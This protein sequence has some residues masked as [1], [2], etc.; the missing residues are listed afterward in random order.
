MKP[1]GSWWVGGRLSLYLF[2]FFL[3]FSPA[4]AV[5]GP[6]TLDLVLAQALAHSWDLHIARKGVDISRYALWEARSLYFPT[7]TARFDNQYVEDLTEDG[8][9]VVS[10]GDQ[11]VSIDGSTYQH[12]VGI[13]LSYLLFDFGAREL[14]VGNTQRDVRI[15]LLKTDQALVDTRLKVL[16]AFARCLELSRRWETGQ[17]ILGHRQELF[18]LTG[19]LRRSGGVG[20]VEVNDAALA[21]AEAVT[22]QEAL[23]RDLEEA[24]L[25]LSY[26]TGED[27]ATE[28]IDFAPLP[29]LAEPEGPPSPELLPEIRAL[30]EEIRKKQ[31]EK[32]ALECSMLPSISLAG[33]YRALGY[34]QDSFSTSLENLDSRDVSV[35][36]VVRWE[37]FSGFRDVSRTLRLS[38]EAEQLKLEKERRLSDLRREMQGAYQAYRLS[39]INTPHIRQRENILGQRAVTDQRLAARQI[40]DRMTWVK[41]E[42]EFREQLLAVDLERMQGRLAGLR[43]RLWREGGNP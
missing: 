28:R 5:A 32:T 13:G 6:L 12:G 1:F 11:T 24:L 37:M 2:P 7:L 26:F 34:D 27:Y 18:K 43:L 30:D 3:F 19:R 4:P 15:A 21:L 36:L 22:D 16:E 35:A 20:Q 38:A 39:Q 42:I 25:S 17:K 41:R 33:S 10:I 14:K 8:N 40:T 29:A 31:K 9:N 23:Q